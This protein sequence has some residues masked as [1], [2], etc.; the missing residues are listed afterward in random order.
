MVSAT[1]RLLVCLL[2]EEFR[3]AS[4]FRRAAGKSLS[5]PGL[6]SI[7]VVNIPGAALAAESRILMKRLELLG[8]DLV[9]AHSNH[10]EGSKVNQLICVHHCL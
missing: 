1:S 9:P 7:Y 10:L 5:A 6:Q 4:I 8:S 3:K 2:L